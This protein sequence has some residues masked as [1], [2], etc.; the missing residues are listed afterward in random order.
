MSQ[1]NK[2]ARNKLNNFRKYRR[3]FW[4]VVDFLYRLRGSTD[5]QTDRQTDR[6]TDRQTDR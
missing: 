3:R 1:I 2:K 4:L 6:P 5:R